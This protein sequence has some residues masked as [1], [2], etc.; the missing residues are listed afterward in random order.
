M[1]YLLEWLHCC[2]HC[3]NQD[4]GARSARVVQTKMKYGRALT[5]VGATDSQSDSDGPDGA[6]EITPPPMKRSK[7]PG[8][9]IVVAQSSASPPVPRSTVTPPTKGTY[10]DGCWAGCGVKVAAPGHGTILSCVCVWS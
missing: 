4:T 9:A 7:G 10:E 6:V 2:D 8:S 5:T 3:L 1:E